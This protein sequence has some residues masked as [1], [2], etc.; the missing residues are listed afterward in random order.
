MGYAREVAAYKRL[1]SVGETGR[2]VPKFYGSWTLKLPITSRAV[3]YQ[4]PVRVLLI[5]HLEGLDLR[6]SRIQNDCLA[7]NGPDA[8][9]LP[10]DYRL[11]VLARVLDIHTRS[12]HWGVNHEDLAS[13]NVM[14]V[15][16]TSAMLS[17]GNNSIITVPRVVLVDFNVSTVYSCTVMG[18]HPLENLARPV[19]PMELFWKWSLAVDFEGWVPREWEDSERFQQQWLL[20]RFGSR[21]Q[22]A[23]YEAVTKE[24]EFSID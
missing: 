4:R 1:E 16:D 12:M 2:S 3:A 24:L 7:Y 5:E 17:A 22:R 14:V 19:N 11:E 10:E 8:F 20:R 23:L 15:T 18:K 9:H 13:R 6:S 21:E